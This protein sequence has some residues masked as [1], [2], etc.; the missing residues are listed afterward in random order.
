MKCPGQDTRY[1]KLGAIFEV[2]CP[3]CGSEVEFFKDDI[4]RRCKQCG[5]GLL[6]PHVDF[7]CASY[8]HYAEQCLGDLPAE[9]LAEKDDLLKDRVAVETKRYLGQDFKRIGHAANVARYAERMVN[10]ERGDPAVVLCAA[11]L[12]DIGLHEAERKYNGTGAKYHQKEGPP[13]AREI[14][15]KLGAR[16]KLVEEVCDIVGHH[17]MPRDEETLNFKIVH[18]ADLIVN[19]EE[20][21]K[22]RK[23]HRDKLREIIEER[24]LTRA[25]KRLARKALLGEET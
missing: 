5:Q 17:H 15:T 6:N 19:L 12:H 4:T 18:D 23:T 21:Q 2:K 10:D 20:R 13:I 25:G 3:K 22:D 8:C 24:I 1:W 7:G 16:G 14:L 9:L 11:F